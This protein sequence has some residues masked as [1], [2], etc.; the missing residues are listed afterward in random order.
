MKLNNE[1]F[2]TC[3]LIRILQLYI[4]IRSAQTVK[5]SLYQVSVFMLNGN[6]RA[7]RWSFLQK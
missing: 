4:E 5:D 1:F 3:I 6:I 7:L 2:L